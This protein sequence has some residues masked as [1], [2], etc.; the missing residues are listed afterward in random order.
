M[1]RVRLGLS[2]AH[3]SAVGRVLVVNARVLLFRECM[4]FVSNGKKRMIIK[5]HIGK[6]QE[7]NRSKFARKVWDEFLIME[8]P[9][10]ASG[11]L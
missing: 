6:G 10:V 7:A 3:L 5:N 11:L 2:Q 8:M 9:A 1:P 4:G